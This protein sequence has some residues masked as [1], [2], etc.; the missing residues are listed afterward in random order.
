MNKAAFNHSA[1]NRLPHL[2]QPNTKRLQ[3]SHIARHYDL[4][5][6]FYKL[7]LDKTMTYSCAYFKKTSDT[8]EVAQEQKLAHTLKKLQLGPGMRLLD[9]GSGW[10]QLL[11]AAV[12]TYGVTGHGI[13]LSKEQYD[14]SRKKVK[15]RSRK[16]WLGIRG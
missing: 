11:I 14:L 9:I 12:Q 8:L 1:F 15:E 6:N 10:G 2:R 7:W 13:T 4:G 16:R 3:R 5:N